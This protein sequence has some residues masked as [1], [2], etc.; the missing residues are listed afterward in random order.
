MSGNTLEIDGNLVKT[1]SAVEV[2]TVAI[3][4]SQ[5]Y[6][7]YTEQQIIVAASG[8]ESINL[9]GMG[10]PKFLYVETDNAVTFKSYRGA[11]V[12]ASAIPIET[13]LLIT[14]NAANRYGTVTISNAGASEADVN[15]YMAA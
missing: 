2:L 11:S 4:P 13:S 9:G 15:V 14:A 6:T 10:Y 8:S 5:A 12:I 1:V 3:N 7:E